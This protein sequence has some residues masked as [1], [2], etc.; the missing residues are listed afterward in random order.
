MQNY[1]MLM[2]FNNY[3]FFI[4]LGGLKR[5]INIFEGKNIGGIQIV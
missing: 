1:F 2:Y 5:L 4:F 3:Y